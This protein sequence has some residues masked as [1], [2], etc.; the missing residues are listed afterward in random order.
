MGVDFMEYD[1]EGLPLSH[2]GKRR[3]NMPITVICDGC[4][5]DAVK[6]K[7]GTYICKDCRLCYQYKYGKLVR[8]TY[9]VHTK[10]YK[11]RFG[12]TREK[13]S[14]ALGFMLQNGEYVDEPLPWWLKK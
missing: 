8:G 14:W 12:C 9:T 4:G 6:L 3:P 2:R 10:E 7:Y 11:D 13:W 1:A 5:K